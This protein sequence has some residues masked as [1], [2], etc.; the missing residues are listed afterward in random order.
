MGLQST[1]P[2]DAKRPPVG[3]SVPSSHHPLLTSKNCRYDSGNRSFNLRSVAAIA[4]SLA[5]GKPAHRISLCRPPHRCRERAFPR[6][7][8][9]RY[10]ATKPL[11]HPPTASPVA[12]PQTLPPCLFGA[13]LTRCRQSNSASTPIPRG[14]QRKM[15]CVSASGSPLISNTDSTFSCSPSRSKVTAAFARRWP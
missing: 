1:D 6:I 10:H 15:N 7:L 5:G 13:S 12:A 14:R 2:G 11:R 3:P 8:T 4:A 9:C